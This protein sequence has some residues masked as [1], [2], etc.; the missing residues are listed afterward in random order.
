M[1]KHVLLCRVLASAMGAIA[2]LTV[3]VTAHA[4]DALAYSNA[5]GSK[6]VELYGRIQGDYR[7]YSN[8]AEPSTFE[9]RR[10]YL[11]IKGMF[12]NTTRYKVAAHL[13]NVNANGQLGALEDAWLE[14]VIHPGA[15]LR[16][17]QFYTPFSLEDATSSKYLDFMERASIINQA[18]SGNDGTDTGVMLYGAPISGMNYWLAHSNG[19][20][21]NAVN[22][23]VAG[24]R[25]TLLRGV[26]DFARLSGQADAVYH[27]GLDYAS[28]R[29]PGPVSGASTLSAGGEIGSLRSEAR[30]KF[31]R[32]MKLGDIDNDYRR[33]RKALELA[34]AH[35]PL[36]FQGE[37]VDENYTGTTLAGMNYDK[38]VR[39]QY[40]NF[41]W[42]VTGE[43]YA[44]HYR[45]GSFGKTDPYRNYAPDHGG[46][47]AWEIGLRYSRLD[48]GDL[49]SD[50]PVG[51][52]KNAAGF[53]TGMHSMTLGL[54]WIMNPNTRMLFNYSHSR[55][56]QATAGGTGG[57]QVSSDDAYMMRAQFDF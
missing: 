18:Q 41:M 4:D 39:G 40:A 35:G 3:G 36:K 56:D 57:T 10:V 47:G 28:G 1:T 21:T 49:N 31:F 27:L 29:K 30:S 16:I 17:G 24:G 5:D 54:K 34:W 11:G 37:I 22:G 12:W 15:T 19:A 38:T 52:L 50:A 14:P 46:W 53:A 13:H 45:N 32:P 25:E 26:L 42:M 51:V 6:T 2:L 7:T 8:A 48:A 33:T 9:M 44:D 43:Q 55:Y 23:D 20:S